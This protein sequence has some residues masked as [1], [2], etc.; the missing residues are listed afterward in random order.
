MKNTARKTTRK[1]S[2]PQTRATQVRP[3]KT[4]AW[5]R[6]WA[7]L[8][9]KPALPINHPIPRLTLPPVPPPPG[10]QT[11]ARAL[12]LLL[13]ALRVMGGQGGA[14]SSTGTLCHHFPHPSEN[15]L[16][17]ANSLVHSPWTTRVI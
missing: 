13:L 15:P 7:A 3:R 17:R 4:S 1:G 12:C 14:G 11:K 8:H 6:L 16:A 5:M 2:R 10:R 9:P